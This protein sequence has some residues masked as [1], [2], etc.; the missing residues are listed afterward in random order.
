VFDRK[1]MQFLDKIQVH[2][3]FAVYF[4]EGFAPALAEFP[5]LVAANV[6]FP[7][8]KMGQEFLP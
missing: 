1:L 6:E 3:V 8:M 7:R 2:A 4:D 5:R